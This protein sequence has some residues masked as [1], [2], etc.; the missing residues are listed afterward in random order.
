VGRESRGKGQEGKEKGINKRREERER[1][2][3]GYEGNERRV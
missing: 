3:N 1:G 2:E